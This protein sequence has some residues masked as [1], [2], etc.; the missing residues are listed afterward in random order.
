MRVAFSGLLFLYTRISKG[1]KGAVF[2]LVE[3][4]ASLDV[5]RFFDTMV[6]LRVSFCSL[7]T[8]VN[9]FLMHVM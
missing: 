5:Y 6:F 1:G 4:L 8:G 7:Y 9:C 2:G 3:V